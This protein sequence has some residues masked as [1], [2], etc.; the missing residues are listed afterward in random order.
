MR[1]AAVTGLAGP[2]CAYTSWTKAPVMPCV[3]LGVS[4]ANDACALA[5][6]RSAA[7]INCG[8]RALVR[9]CR[10]PT[11]DSVARGNG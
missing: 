10:P 5:F 4:A 1:V 8:W 7:V 2:S 9:H 3:S 6:P 11:M